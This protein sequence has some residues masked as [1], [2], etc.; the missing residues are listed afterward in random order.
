MKTKLWLTLCATG[1]L[2]ACT[3][4]GPTTSPDG[5]INPLPEEVIAAAAPY[6]N[7]NAVQINPIDGCYEYQHIGPVETTF[8][9]LRTSNGRAICTV[10]PEQV[11]EAG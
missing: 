8:L 3:E 10:A 4:F 2:G 1:L 9:P 5:F 11:A 7:L 6:Q